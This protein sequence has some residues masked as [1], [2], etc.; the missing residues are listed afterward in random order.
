MVIP[1]NPYVKLE[2]RLWTFGLAS[3]FTPRALAGQVKRSTSESSIAG[4]SKLA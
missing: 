3:T 4:T 2:R 1:C